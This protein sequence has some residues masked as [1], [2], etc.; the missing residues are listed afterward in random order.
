V[1][2]RLRPLTSEELSGYIDEDVERYIA[3]RVRSGER[4]EVARRIAIEQS[5]ALFPDG[6][7]AAG[8]LLFRVLDDD[9]AAVGLL[10]IGP[11]D[12]DRPEAL[13]VWDVRIEEAS[14]GKGLGRAA[15]QLAEAEARGRGAIELGLNVFGHNRVARHLYESMGYVATSIRMK[16][17]L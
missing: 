10:W 17:D 15:M 1:P 5:K 4:P 6:S 9:G 12:A 13:W 14:Q 2:A 7:P 16:K 11:Q 3:E 8:H